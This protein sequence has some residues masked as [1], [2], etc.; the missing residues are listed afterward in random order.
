MKYLNQR[1]TLVRKKNDGEPKMMHCPIFYLEFYKFER[2]PCL[3]FVAYWLLVIA[4]YQQHISHTYDINVTSPYHYI[5]MSLT[6][7]LCFLLLQF[8]VVVVV[9]VV[10][11]E[12]FICKK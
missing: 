10:V 6:Q 1:K 12:R 2:G 8:I 9:V 4:C 7:N 11:V 3:P 5:P